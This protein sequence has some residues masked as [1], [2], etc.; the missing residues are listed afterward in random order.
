VT[1]KH[2][3]TLTGWTAKTGVEINV[4]DNMNLVITYQY[5]S[6]NDVTWNAN[7]PLTG[8]K[9]T[10]RYKPVINSITLGLGMF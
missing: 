3:S 6:Y 2:E 1:G 10:A 8:V 4:A 9:V 7:E 5:T